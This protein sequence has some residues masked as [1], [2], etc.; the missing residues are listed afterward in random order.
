MCLFRDAEGKTPVRREVSFS[1]HP[2]SAQQLEIVGQGGRLID[3]HPHHD[4]LQEEILDEV[5]LLLARL[6]RER[7]RL[8]NLCEREGEI[9]VRLKDNIDHWRLKRLQDLPLA[10]QKGLSITSSFASH[11]SLVF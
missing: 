10:V 8:I 6:D 1:Q 4:L 9:R 7:L 5:L 3:Q 2:S 11:F